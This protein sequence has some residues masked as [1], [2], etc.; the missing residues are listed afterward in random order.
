M[1]SIRPGRCYTPLKRAYTRKSKFKKLAFIKSV[2]PSKIVKFEYGELT[3]KFGFEVTLF[4]KEAIQLRHNAIESAR[5][6]VIRKLEPL[7]KNFRLK[8]RIYPHHILRENKMI[9]GAG[10]DRMSKGMQR[11]FGR[12]IGLA[13]RMKKGKEVFSVYVDKQD[14]ELAKQALVSATYRMPLKAEIRVKQ[15]AA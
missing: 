5:T 12:A 3:R 15:L 7:G 1:V 13:A 4:T 6:V 14:V 11:A 2:P 10:A 8:I 9:T